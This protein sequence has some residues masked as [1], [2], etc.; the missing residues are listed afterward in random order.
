MKILKVKINKVVNKW[1]KKTRGRAQGIEYLPKKCQALISN[2]ISCLT[3]LKPNIYIYVFICCVCHLYTVLYKEQK[4]TDFLHLFL[5]PFINMG[6]LK[7]KL[8]KKKHSDTW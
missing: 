5:K 3:P 2:S 1:I 7:S 8:K 4:S 6:S